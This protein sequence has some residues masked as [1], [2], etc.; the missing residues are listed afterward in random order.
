LEALQRDLSSSQ[1]KG[2]GWAFLQFARHV[3]LAVTGLMS[4]SILLLPKRD[5]PSSSGAEAQQGP[6]GA[7]AG[8]GAG[9]SGSRSQ[10]TA[11]GQPADVG[12]P[13]FLAHADVAHWEQVQNHPPAPD[14]PPDAA[15][16]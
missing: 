1:S 4:V 7:G 2:T 10:A 6:A 16:Q 8:A 9:A 3:H 13:S 15:L 12:Q 11:Q 5:E 14:Q